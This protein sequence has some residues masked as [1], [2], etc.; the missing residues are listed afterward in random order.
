MGIVAPTTYFAATGA[1]TTPK[2]V[3]VTNQR[4]QYRQYLGSIYYFMFL[5]QP[6]Y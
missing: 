2:V 4:K 5:P 6:S 1:S 3:D